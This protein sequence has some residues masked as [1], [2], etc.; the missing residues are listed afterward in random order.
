MLTL[1]PSFHACILQIIQNRTYQPERNETNAQL[2][3]SPFEVKICYGILA[4]DSAAATIRLIEALHEPTTQFIVHID[5]KFE[6]TY[7][8]MKDY[9]AGKDRVILLDDPYRVRVNWGGF[10]MVNATMQMINYAENNNLDFTHFIHM[11]ATAYPIASNRRIRNTLAAYP[12]DANFLHIILKPNRPH[13]A[14]WNYFVECDDRLHRIHRLPPMTKETHG[15][16][17]YTSSQW[18]MISKEFA[19]FLANPEL[20]EEDSFL[21]QYWDYIQHV[22]VAD[23]SFFGTVL[24]NTQ[25]CNKVRGKESLLFCKCHGT[26]RLLTLRLLFLYSTTTGISCIC[27]LINGRT[28]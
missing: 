10:Q 5:A 2:F 12:I 18:F 16:D 6:E 11:A 23:E 19:S 26:N 1:F 8:E 27:S 20:A 3:I 14:I 21:R 17:F 4:H 25:F 24:R 7:Q 15:A 28:K 22:V 13:H 9:A